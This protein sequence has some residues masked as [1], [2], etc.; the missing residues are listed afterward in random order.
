MK[1]ASVKELKEELKFQSPVQLVE[2]CLRL[3]KFKKENKQ[4]LTY[5]LFEASNE[6]A[7]ISA[8]KQEIDIEFEQINKD[9]VYYIKKSVRK[10]LR[11]TKTHIRYSKMKE[12]EVE[13]LIHY[14][15]RLKIINSD[16]PDNIALQNIFNRQIA[17]IKKA[18][19][20]LHEDLRFDYKTELEELV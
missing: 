17:L 16:F 15:S 20:S 11:H 2:L 4:L 7:Y 5:L 18:M 14:C 9:S 13:L 1:T 8:V 19:Q 10:I 6:T 12:T 3:S